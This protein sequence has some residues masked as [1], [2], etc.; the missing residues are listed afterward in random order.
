M[1]KMVIVQEQGP[2]TRLEAA[3]IY[4]E[5]SKSLETVTIVFCLKL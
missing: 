1:T 3:I 2:E 4:F 5:Q